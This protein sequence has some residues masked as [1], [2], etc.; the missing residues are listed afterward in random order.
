MGGEE[1]GREGGT[2][3]SDYQHYAPLL[4]CANIPSEYDKHSSSSNMKF[5]APHDLC[6]A[7]P[8]GITRNPISP[9]PHRCCSPT[10]AASWPSDTPFPPHLCLFDRHTVGTGSSTST[11]ELTQPCPIQRSLCMHPSVR[12][13]PPCPPAWAP[14]LPGAAPP[15]L[16]G[17]RP[18]G[19]GGPSCDPPAGP[20]WSRRGGT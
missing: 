9:Q 8:A 12:L 2:N 3:N 19:T 16:G 4:L 17:Q 18:E 15:S 7:P 10:F 14:S 11:T 13:H 5:A 1:G 20:R 6:L